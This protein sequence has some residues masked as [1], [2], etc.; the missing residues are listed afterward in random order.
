MTLPSTPSG[1][2]ESPR[3]PPPPPAP[4]AS[5]ARFASHGCPGARAL[6]PRP[7]PRAGTN[8]ARQAPRGPRGGC[9][10][11]SST[12]RRQTRFLAKS[13]TLRIRMCTSSPGV[14]STP[15]RHVSVT[16]VLVADSRAQARASVT[17]LMPPPCPPPGRLLRLLSSVL[18]AHP[19]L[20]ADSPDYSPPPV[21]RGHSR[22]SPR[23]LTLSGG[24]Q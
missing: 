21:C 18:H 9:A 5:V 19:L 13:V 3:R 16:A 11:T 12:P 17:W 8:S 4:S 1:D 7:V 20:Q 15:S 23:H 24:D 6:S 2:G 14:P 10:A 22:T